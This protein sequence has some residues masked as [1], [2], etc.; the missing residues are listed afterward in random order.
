MNETLT[1]TLS[2]FCGA[3]SFA[4]AKAP[5]R[6]KAKLRAMQADAAESPAQARDARLGRLM[7]RAQD[8]DKAAYAQL[9]RDCAPVIRRVA[10]RQGAR[11]DLL[12]DVVQEALLTVHRARATY[13]PSRSFTAWLATIAQRRAIDA[14]RRTGRQGSREVHAPIAYE[15]HPDAG[16]DPAALSERRDDASL[17]ADHVKSLPNGQREAV[18][19]LAYRELTLEEA[20]QATGRSKTALKVNLHR[21]I[22]S[23][24]SRMTGR[25]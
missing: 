18:E 10:G 21:A 20:A 9:L 6:E 3:P 22:K 4:E 19:H 16:P 7:A 14:L 24:R 11:G 17:L 23:L 12:D 5:A 25:E 1:E 8:G 2:G 15:A 13:D